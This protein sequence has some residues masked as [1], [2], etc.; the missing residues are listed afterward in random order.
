MIAAYSKRARGENRGTEPRLV[1]IY[2]LARIWNVLPAEIKR[3]PKREVDEMIIMANL[4]YQ[5][6]TPEEPKEVKRRG[7]K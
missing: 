7:Y 6:G 2:D 5:Y 1:M 4:Y 3:L